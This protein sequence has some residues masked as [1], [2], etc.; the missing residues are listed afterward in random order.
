MKNKMAKK[1]NNNNQPENLLSKRMRKTEHGKQTGLY[2]QQVEIEI[3]VDNNAQQPEQPFNTDIPYSSQQQ[4]FPPQTFQ[5]PQQPFQTQQPPSNNI[6]QE[7]SVSFGTPNQ[8]PQ[9]GS[10]LKDKFGVRNRQEEQ[11]PSSGIQEFTFDAGAM[12]PQ[13]DTPVF[14]D[15]YTNMY[16]NKKKQKREKPQTHEIGENAI[17]GINGNPFKKKLS[18]KVKIIALVSII[19]SIL[20][21]PQLIFRIPALI[22][23]SNSEILLQVD[24]SAK[25]KVTEY[26]KVQ[27]GVDDWDKDGLPNSAD[28]NP[29]D[30]D[31]DRNGIPDGAKSED[32]IKEGDIISYEN[33]TFMAKNSS[34]GVSKFMN[35]YVFQNYKGWVKITDVTG[36]PYIHKSSGWTEAKYTREGSAYLVYIPKDCFIE[37]VSD[38][39]FGVYCTDFLGN[40]VFAEKEARY[41]KDYGFFAPVLSV[42]YKT[43]LPATE[44]TDY[45]IS[46]VWNSDTYHIIKQ[47]NLSK[48][49]AKKPNDENYN[50]SVLK[51][52]E[53]SYEKLE[54]LYKNIDEKRTVLIS[55]ITKDGS[56]ATCFAYAYDYL[57]NIYVCDAKTSKTAGMIKISP[58]AQ[59]YYKDG[60]KFMREWYEFEGLGFSTEKGD[61]LFIY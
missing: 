49:E 34:H 3:A 48:A 24:S 31:S 1:S 20:L 8:E 30:P 46:S 36:I 61:N 44:P 32:F 11:S 33:V 45:S 26:I 4:G 27:N 42:L 29:H 50:M 14:D 22:S 60:V 9:Q 19:A 2:G 17:S 25:D 59:V 16:R 10:L 38:D 23:S 6:P 55:I 52:Y 12:D 47:N 28:E 37:F 58:K 15:R 51:D 56:E 13:T 7:P 40:K 35:Y 18:K 41:V 54:K 39:T 53:F 43:F 57:G 21:I 5:Q